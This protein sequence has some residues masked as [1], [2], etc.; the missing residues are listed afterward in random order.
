MT[1]NPNVETT[2]Q[3]PAD[4]FLLWLRAKDEDP[5]DFVSLHPIT[6]RAQQWYRTN[7]TDDIRYLSNLGAYELRD[8]L[9]AEGFHVGCCR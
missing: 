9:R 1:E 3:N 2:D 6:P 5:D 7:P 4:D 8:H